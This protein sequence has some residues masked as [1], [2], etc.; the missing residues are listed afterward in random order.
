MFQDNDF[1]TWR[2]YDNRAWPTFYLVD[3]AGVVR[4]V[5]RGEISEVFPQGVAPLEAKIKQL[6]A[7]EN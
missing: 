2:A 6:L 3:R 4:Y 5:H 1:A 7:E